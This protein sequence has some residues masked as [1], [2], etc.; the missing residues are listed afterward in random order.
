VW[1]ESVPVTP[2]KSLVDVCR[3]HLIASVLMVCGEDLN[4]LSRREWEGR[5]SH[6]PKSGYDHDSALL[7]MATVQVYGRLAMGSLCPAG[8]G[9][10]QEQSRSLL[11]ANADLAQAWQSGARRPA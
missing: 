8:W 6:A 11:A 3:K 4:G 10:C 2:R 9:R 5:F 1:K 7:R